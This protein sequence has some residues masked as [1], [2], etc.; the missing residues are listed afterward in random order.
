MVFEMF[1]TH[2][3]DLDI[4]NQ[5]K[6]VITKLGGSADAFEA[7]AM[8]PAQAEVDAITTEA[9]RLGVFGVPS[10]LLDG[11][12]FWGGDRVD[13]LIRRLE[14]RAKGISPPGIAVAR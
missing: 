9:E 7:Y 11:E 4:L 2:Q 6:A 14:Q 8:G 10:M 12:L 1:W 3:L 13:M 5:M